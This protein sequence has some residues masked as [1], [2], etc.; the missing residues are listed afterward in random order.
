MAVYIVV[1]IAVKGDVM[2]YVMVRAR[3]SQSSV[4]WKIMVQVG[5][6]GLNWIIASSESNKQAIPMHPVS[7]V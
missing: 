5:F 1:N 4:V 3:A 2:W 7:W 6:K